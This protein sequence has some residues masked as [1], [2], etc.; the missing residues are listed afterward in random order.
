LSYP[1]NDLAQIA[2]AIH[3]EMTRPLSKVRRKE[4]GCPHYQGATV[5]HAGKVPSSV[6]EPA[7]LLLPVAEWPVVQRRCWGSFLTP[8]YGPTALRPGTAATHRIPC[9]RLSR[10]GMCPRRRGIGQVPPE[11][12]PRAIRCKPPDRQSGPDRPA[13]RPRPSEKTVGV[14]PRLVRRPVRGFRCVFRVQAVSI[15]G[16][17][18]RPGCWRW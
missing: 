5:T 2:D 18:M 8:T 15:F 10:Y 17:I 11:A 16:P 6:P 13:R 12:R 7:R 1:P 3:Q 14:A 4:I 9:G